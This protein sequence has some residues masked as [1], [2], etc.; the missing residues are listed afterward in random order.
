MK[1]KKFW[2]WV[3]NDAG[4]SDVTDKPTTRTLYL[5]GVISS[6]GWF[7]DDVTPKMFKDELESIS[8]FGSIALVETCTQQHRFTICS[9]RTTARLP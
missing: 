9:N 2:N 3:K 7:D 8:K 5:N 4:E 6:E 1:N